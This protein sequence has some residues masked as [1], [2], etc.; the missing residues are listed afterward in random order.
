MAASGKAKANGRQAIFITGAASGIGLSTA[1]RFARGGWFV[2]LADI[3][4]KGLAAALQAIGPDNGVAHKLDVRHRS[5]W[6]A[7]LAA[8]ARLTDGRLDVLL[9]N[10]GVAKGGYL[11]AQAPDEVDLQVDVNLKGVLNGCQAAFELLAAT[12]GAMVVNVASVAGVVAPPRMS[13]YAATKF[14]VRGL[15]E[16]LEAEFSRIGVGVRCIMPWF[17][18]TPLLD[19]ARFSGNEDLRVSLR[20]Q[21]VPVYPVEQVS[22][23]IWAAVH[24][25]PRLHHLVGG[26]ARQL[27]LLNRLLPDLV[28]KRLQ[29][30]VEAW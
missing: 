20:H 25:R 12:P 7:E 22:D 15:S 18:D 13:V 8:F 27:G 19:K 23:A 16:A 10:A 30:Q 29:R 4:A 1:R 3:D 26:Q 14:A 9:N 6:K 28:R 11:E 17:I 21:K 5:A 24:G 2:G